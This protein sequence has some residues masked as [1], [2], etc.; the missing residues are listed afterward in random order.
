MAHK[1]AVLRYQ[2]E[3]LTLV[4]VGGT[5]R[6]WF[7]L[8]ARVCFVDDTYALDAVIDTVTGITLDPANPGNWQSTIG[9]KIGTRGAELGFTLVS[10]DIK[11]LRVPN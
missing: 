3:E 7:T 9:G 11:Q 1:C 8:S 2:D 6:Q 4:D 5:M 10:A